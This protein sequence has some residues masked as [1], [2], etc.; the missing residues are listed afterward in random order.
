M[1]DSMNNEEQ[2]SADDQPE[3]VAR[4]KLLKKLVWVPPAIV[5]TASVRARAAE[6]T[7]NPGATGDGS[8]RP[9]P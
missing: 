8:C 2:T 5:A 4:R 6:G 1:S 3:S 9:S 7:C